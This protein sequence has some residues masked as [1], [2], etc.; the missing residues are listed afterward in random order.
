M[1]EHTFRKFTDDTKLC[2]VGGRNAMQR[3]LENLERWACVNLKF[4]QAM[5]R[6]L[7]LG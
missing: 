7:H 5:C 3:H 6:V 4:N 1:I 2:G